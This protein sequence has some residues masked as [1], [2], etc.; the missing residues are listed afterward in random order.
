MDYWLPAPAPAGWVLC[1][2]QACPADKPAL[3]AALIAA[4]NPYGTFGG[5]PLLPDKRGRASFGK[6][7]MGGS[8]AG[9]LTS[10]GSGITG[11]TLGAAGGAQ[12][13]TLTTGQIPVITPTGISLGAGTISTGSVGV[14]VVSGTVGSGYTAYASDTGSSATITSQFSDP[15]RNLS[16]NAFGSGQA[17]NNVPPGIVSNYIIYAGV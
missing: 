16:M 14:R 4:G 3:R 9:R 13:H 5:N 6:D 2:A 12:T 10:G 1:Y 11:T 17:H 8:A 7:D 15:D